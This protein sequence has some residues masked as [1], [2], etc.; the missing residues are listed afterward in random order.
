[1]GEWLPE[2]HL[3]WFVLDAV[4]ELDL[5]PFYASYRR[6]GWGAAA[7]DPQMMVALL[8]YAYAIGERSSRA[9]EH[10][11]REDVAFR[12][13]AANQIP[14]HATS[15]A[16]ASVTR[17]RAGPREG[18]DSPTALRGTADRTSPLTRLCDTL[19]RK[20]HR[21]SAERRGLRYRLSTGADW[22]APDTAVAWIA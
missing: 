17:R 21:S 11:L 16:S 13:I 7:H 4:V 1:M 2:D 5:E 20:R 19:T 10:R 3:A 22:W 8:I 12:V 14:D 6:D 9:I 15:R 18:P